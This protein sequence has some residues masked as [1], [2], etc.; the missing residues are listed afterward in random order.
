MNKIHNLKENNNTDIFN[1]ILL[2][3]ENDFLNM[4]NKKTF[5]SVIT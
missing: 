4:F 2:T 3:N 1:T 5:E